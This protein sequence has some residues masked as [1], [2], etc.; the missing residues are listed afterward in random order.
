M[1]LQEG[2]YLIPDG[3]SIKRVGRTIQVY[4]SKTHLLS[5]NDH[6]CK[7]CIHYVDGYS[8]NSGWFMTKVC[9]AQIKRESKDGKRMLYHAAK[10]Y[11]KICYKFEERK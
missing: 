6:R 2:E 9:D 3:Y 1:Y 5:E 11:G 7:D 4:K 10:K 8:L